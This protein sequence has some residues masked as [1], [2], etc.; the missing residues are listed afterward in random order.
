[1][2]LLLAITVCAVL[3]LGATP[4][5][6]ADGSWLD[7][8]Q[9]AVWN[10]AGMPPPPGPPPAELASIDPRCL[11]QARWPET[12]EDDAVVA[13]GWLL[14]GAYQ[15]GWGMRIITAA[16][17]FD[18][19]CRPLGYQGF[20]FVD[21]QFAG[22]LSPVAMNSRTDGAAGNPTISGADRIVATFSR[23]A[24]T[25]PLCCPSRLTYAAFRID[26]SAGAP[27]LQLS[28]VSPSPTGPTP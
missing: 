10:S 27:V 25:D 7:A 17:G 8:E 20:V 11:T 14:S 6:T 18:G 16:G 24:D 21:G 2:K 26:R 1:M 13:A 23:Y 28:S 3:L 19:M 4:V 15:S 22:T 9:P 12:E 5:A